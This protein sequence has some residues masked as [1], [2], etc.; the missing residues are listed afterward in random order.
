MENNKD[1]IINFSFHDS[2]CDYDVNNK[3]HAKNDTASY[4]SESHRIYC[5]E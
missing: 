1:T 5:I 4:S 2:L 3:R